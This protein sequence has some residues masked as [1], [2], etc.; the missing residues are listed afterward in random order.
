ML[1]IGFGWAP[2]DDKWLIMSKRQPVFRRVCSRRQASKLDQSFLRSLKQ[3]HHTGYSLANIAPLKH[4]DDYLP[5]PVDGRRGCFRRIERVQ[6]RFHQ[7]QSTYVVGKER[8]IADGDVSARGM[9]KDPQRIRVTGL[10]NRF[11][12]AGLFDNSGVLTEASRAPI[13]QSI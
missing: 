13:S 3:L 7:D 4:R 5:H 12:R 10:A 8:G 9:T 11:N 2:V 1:N 6:G